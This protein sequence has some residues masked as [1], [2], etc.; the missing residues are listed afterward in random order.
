MQL[1]RNLGTILLGIW[2]IVAGL[3]PLLRIGI[4]SSDVILLCLLALLLILLRPAQR[5]RSLG[6]ILVCIWLIVKGLLPL[7]PVLRASLPYPDIVLSLL[8]I[9]AGILVLVGR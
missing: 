3:L 8:A 1:T 7:L 4:P 5:R 2:L 6:V 9:I